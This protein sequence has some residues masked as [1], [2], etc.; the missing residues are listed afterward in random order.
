MRTGKYAL[1]N[2]LGSMAYMH[3]DR[4]IFKDG[5]VIKEAESTLIAV[6]P[7]RQD[8]AHG[9]MWDEG[10]HQ[11]LISMWNMNLTMD[12]VESWFNQTDPKTGWICRE[13]MLGREIRAS[14]PPSSWPQVPSEA[15][16]PSQHMLLGHLLDRFDNDLLLK[17]EYYVEFIAFLGRI[18]DNLKLNVDW[19]LKTQAS[20][21]MSD[22]FRWKG[23]TSRYCLASG[24]DDYPRAPIMT[25]QEAHIDLQT[26]MIISTNL[27]SRVAGVL[28]K[29]DDELHYWNLV[30]KYR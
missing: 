30:V 12:I 18:Y 3:G 20:Q 2:M 23:R 27:L 11:H 7:D 25:E 6:V 22:T 14:A 17:K 13:Q 28:E 1:S 9:F 26:W 5:K 21:V 15:N 8:H 29:R 19:F 24:M 4:M 16:P 10:F